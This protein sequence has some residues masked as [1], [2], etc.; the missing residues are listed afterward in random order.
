MDKYIN[1]QN[2]GSRND[3]QIYGKFLFNID[4]KGK[5]DNAFNKLC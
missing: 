5:K 2:R 3:L 4:A 1:E